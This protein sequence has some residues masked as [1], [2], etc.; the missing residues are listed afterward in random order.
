MIRRIFSFFI[1]AFLCLVIL[2]ITIPVTLILPLAKLDPP[3]T[4]LQAQRRVAALT[5]FRSYRK[6]QY[7]I[8]L[9][10][11]SPRLQRAVITA[12]DGAFYEHNGIDFVQ[13]QKAYEEGMNGGRQ[14]GASTITMQLAKN[15]YLWE[16]FSMVDT[17]FRKGLEVYLALWLELLLSKDR[18]LE[19]YLNVIEWGDGVYG[20]E[21]ASH[22]YFKINAKDLNSAQSARMARF[23]PSPLRRG[24]RFVE[25]RDRRP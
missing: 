21:A 15:L 19:L 1:K 25:R 18:I 22:H 20:V 8:S 11:I 17:A 3:T 16:G 2:L 9:E 4:S 6:R 7:W 10:A 5:H 23:L 24:S 12:E 14:R 13:A